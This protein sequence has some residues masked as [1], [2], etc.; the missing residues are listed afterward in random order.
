ME[1]QTD[2]TGE[3]ASCVKSHFKNVQNKGS[4]RKA[5]KEKDLASRK[6]KTIRTIAG[7]SIKTLNAQKAQCEV[8]RNPSDYNCQPGWL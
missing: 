4:T 1:H 7:F 2:K 5:S 8:F 6:D 3:G